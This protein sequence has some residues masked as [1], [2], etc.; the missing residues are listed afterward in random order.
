MKQAFLI[1]MMVL[2]VAGVGCG[3]S[4]SNPSG[5][6]GSGGGT[7]GTGG[8]AG[9]GGVGGNT[10]DS[11]TGCASDCDDGFSCTIDS[12][13]AGKC[14][15]AIGPNT[16]DTACPTGQYCTVEQGCI[17]APAC[18]D[19]SDC[20]KA[21]AGDACKANIRCDAASSICLFDLLD[22]DHD[23]HPPQVCGGGDCN[24]NDASIHPGAIEQCDGVDKDC[25]GV[26]DN[27][28][29]CSDPLE[30]CQAG[31][32][33]CRP[34]NLCG[35][36]C[37]DR[38]ADTNNCGACGNKCDPGYS[39]ASGSC[40]CPTGSDVC[41]GVCVSLMYDNDNCGS[42]GH[43]CSDLELC[44]CGVC[45]CGDE[46]GGSQCGGVSVG[47]SPGI[48]CGMACIDP[49]TDTANCGTCGTICGGGAPCEHGACQGGDPC[50]DS[51]NCQSGQGLVCD[52]M[53]ATCQSGQCSGN[54]PCP[55]GFVCLDQQ[56]TMSGACYAACAYSGNPACPSNQTCVPNPEWFEDGWVCMNQGSAGPGA[57]CSSHEIGTGCAAGYR[58]QKSGGGAFC[59]K[60]CDFWNS[61]TCP[62]GSQKCSVE[63]GCFANGDSVAIGGTCSAG[64]GTPCGPEGNRWAGTCVE[65]VVPSDPPVCGRWCRVGSNADCPGSTCQEDFTPPDGVG[66]CAY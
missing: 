22:K 30:S 36:A 31:S 14:T 64:V 16:G 51:W 56:A 34:E 43:A 54:N 21:F 4:E 65:A 7:A 49:E 25:D 3:N 2:V 55:N 39:C 10:G 45:K 66:L 62:N 27:G 58:C 52:P 50:Q 28:A 42:C 5:T 17:A 57:S 47:K 33:Q 48:R 35:T 59:G 40:T 63:G 46:P 18:A 6:G 15:H 9:T 8:A 37:V 1:G 26:V 11:G 60:V 61:P 23:G 29:T 12:C 13:A 24:D 41:S 20:E 38:Q 53:T 19:V 44:D 32:C